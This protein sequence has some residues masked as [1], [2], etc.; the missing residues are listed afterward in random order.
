M[1]YFKNLIFRIG[2]V[3]VGEKVR[4]TFKLKDDAPD[5][6]DMRASCSC[7]SPTYNKESNEVSSILTVPKFSKH[8]KGSTQKIQKSILVNFKDGSQNVLYIKGTKI[9]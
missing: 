5:I 4:A 6:I 1:N 2:E 7:T 3:S 9:R 8:I